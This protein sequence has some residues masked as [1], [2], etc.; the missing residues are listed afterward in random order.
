[1]SGAPRRQ[2]HDEFAAMAGACTGRAN[3][4]PVEL[5]VLS[6]DG[7]SDT[8][9]LAGRIITANERLEDVWE[10]VG[11]NAPSGIADGQ[12]CGRGTTCEIDG[13]ASVRARVLDPV[14]EKI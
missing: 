12:H 1:M 8:E 14:D 10:D 13:H 2:G 3:R 7:Q 11:A 5:D 9:A 4:S 6:C